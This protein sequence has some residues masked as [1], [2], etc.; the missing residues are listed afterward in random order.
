MSSNVT[1]GPVCFTFVKMANVVGLTFALFMVII[2]IVRGGGVAAG[3]GACDCLLLV[4]IRYL[5]SSV[6]VV[7]VVK[8]ACVCRYLIFAI[9]GIALLCLLVDARGILIL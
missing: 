3:A 7:S 2:W 5:V 8:V 6:D 4:V 9:F 1:A